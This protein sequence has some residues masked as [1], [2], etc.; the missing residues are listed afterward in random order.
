MLGLANMSETWELGI[1]T[2]GPKII[3][4]ACN[5]TEKVGCCSVEE[6][7]QDIHVECVSISL[8]ILDYATFALTMQLKVRHISCWNVPYTTPLDIISIHHYLRA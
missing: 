6:V 3:V 4:I 5:E 7:T 2:L 8:E 1:G